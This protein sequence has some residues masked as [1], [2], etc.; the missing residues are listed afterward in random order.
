MRLPLAALLP[1]SLAD[2]TSNSLFVRLSLACGLSIEMML[3]LYCCTT[4]PVIVHAANSK[5][6]Y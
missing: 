2:S 1:V 6:G 3:Q 5:K 4:V